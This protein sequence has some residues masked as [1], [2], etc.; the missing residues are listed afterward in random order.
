LALNRSSAAKS[1]GQLQQGNLE[2]QLKGVGG[3]D[4]ANSKLPN[5]KSDFG[6]DQKTWKRRKTNVEL[7]ELKVRFVG[8]GT[9]TDKSKTRIESGGGD[10]DRGRRWGNPGRQEVLGWDG[11]LTGVTRRRGGWARQGVTKAPRKGLNRK[12]ETP[13]REKKTY[14]EG[15]WAGQTFRPNAGPRSGSA[16]Q[17]GRS[18]NWRHR[19]NG[20]T[21][22]GQRVGVRP[23]KK[24]S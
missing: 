10:A 24:K 18:R 17:K 22:T 16:S 7:P 5:G 15:K 9:K 20:T 19:E 3:W 21:N 1:R 8:T 23:K 11:N 4:L 13:S 14:P 2:R 12:V 6:P